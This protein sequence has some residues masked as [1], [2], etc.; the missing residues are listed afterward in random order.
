MARKWD[1]DTADKSGLGRNSDAWRPT[2]WK[3]PMGGP[4]A[5]K[6]VQPSSKVPAGKNGPGDSQA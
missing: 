5:P 1:N 6:D 4:G 2:D 3:D